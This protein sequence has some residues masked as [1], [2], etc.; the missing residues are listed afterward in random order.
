M[1][2][3]VDIDDDNDIHVLRGNIQWIAEKREKE[4]QRTTF[5]NNCGL[6]AIAATLGGGFTAFTE[7]LLHLSGK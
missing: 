1:R 6:S 4:R 7:W 5:L 2:L 3:G